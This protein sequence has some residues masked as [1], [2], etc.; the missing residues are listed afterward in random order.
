MEK[1][2]IP[3]FV[4]YQGKMA[5]NI[6]CNKETFNQGKN[7]ITKEDIETTIKDH[8]K[9]IKDEEEVEV[10]FYGGSFTS[11]DI[12]KQEEF[13]KTVFKYIQN[14]KIESIKIFSSPEFINKKILKLLKKYNV[15]TIELGVNSTNN[16]ILQ[17]AKIGYT[18]EDIKTA[19]KLIKRYRFK[20][21]YQIMVGLPESTKLDEIKTAKDLAKFRPKIVKIYPLLVKKGTEL[22]KEYN[23]NMYTP[24]TIVQAVETSK[25]IVRIFLKKKTKV[26]RVKE[27]IQEE[28]DIVAGPFHPEFRQLVESSLWYDAIVNKIKELNVKVLEVKVD[29]NPIDV[30]SVIGYKNENI[31]K[32]KETYDVDLI[33]T[34]NENIKQGKSKI[35]IT[36]TYKDFKEE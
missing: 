6:F 19:S 28:N 36:K 13:L 14:K 9:E 35:E 21:G 18:F 11:L 27:S 30:N 10:F 5:D 15:K 22:E 2:I 24:L 31:N 1:H 12:E 8:L 20:L 25:E 26:I 23:E 34:S 33:V 29:V 17:R 4:P 3:I 16:Y 32:L 7:K